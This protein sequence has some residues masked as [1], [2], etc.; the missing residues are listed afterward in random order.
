[1]PQLASPNLELFSSVERISQGRGV[2]RQYSLQ[3]ECF[4]I[5][6]V[7]NIIK[8]AQIRFTCLY[9]FYRITVCGC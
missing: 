5:L 6:I 9:T 2:D 1:M 3:F 4:I 8:L 7:S